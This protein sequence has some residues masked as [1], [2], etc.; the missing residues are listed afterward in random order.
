MS[1][2]LG[3]AGSRLV[4][5]IGRRSHGRETWWSPHL[6][7]RDWGAILTVP[8]SLL[9]L[10]PRAA[11]STA[12][13]CGL[14]EVT[15]REGRWGSTIEVRLEGGSARKRRLVLAALLRAARYARSGPAGREKEA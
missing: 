6:R 3:H 10:A 4:L 15:W 8:L 7:S 9:G 13:C 11:G 5:V 2:R 1:F 12:L 14:G